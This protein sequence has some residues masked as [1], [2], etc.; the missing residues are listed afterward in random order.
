MSG[1]GVSSGSDSFGSGSV[2]GTP[3]SLF[4]QLETLMLGAEREI[5]LLDTFSPRNFVEEVSR[6]SGLLIRSS[7]ALPVFTYAPPRTE[8][9]SQAEKA[10]QFAEHQL[11]GV[12]QDDSWRWLVEVFQNRLEEL[13]LELELVQ[14]LGSSRVA[15]L[16]RQRY[17]LTAEEC[18]SANSLA[19]KWLAE[20]CRSPPDL[21]ETVSVG[22]EF[23]ARARA[24]GL[25]ARIVERDISSIAAVGG[26]CIYV[27]R[28][29]RATPREVERI[30]VHEVGAH[31]LPR[32]TARN[33]PPPFRVGTAQ[34][35]EDEEGRAVVLEARAS[36]LSSERKKTL[37]VRYLLASAARESLDL[38]KVRARE[39]LAQGLL[40][41]DV[42]STICRVCRGGGL[43]RE[44][45]YLTSFER[46]SRALELTPQLE[47]WMKRG[48]I[49]IC[50]ARV[51]TAQFAGEIL[52]P[53]RHPSN[54]G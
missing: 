51:L 34:T 53:S 21:T 29:A 4:Y 28:G 37:A 3:P 35:N 40:A 7:D 30:W 13:R 19:E 38:V 26:E 45:I 16:S 20:P 23:L 1:G 15:A 47:H 25:N 18:E 5:A 36:L 39:L 52:G 12:G 9:W 43:A 22:A 50:G 17:S 10:L 27:Q 24:E 42:A 48:R 33:L 6:V 49:S 2:Q 11:T 54:G 41:N 32:L 14:A 8:A 44:V 46:V 31:L